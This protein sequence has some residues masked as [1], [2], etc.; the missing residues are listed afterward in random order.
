MQVQ[1]VQTAFSKLVLGEVVMRMKT[2]LVMVR[3]MMMMMMMMMS[4]QNKAPNA[5]P[6]DLLEEEE[7]KE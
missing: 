2:T 3:V 4:V 7:K 5:T 1:V 6:V